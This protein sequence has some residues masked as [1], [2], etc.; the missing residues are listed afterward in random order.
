MKNIEESRK[1]FVEI[2][3]GGVGNSEFRETKRIRFLTLCQ[4]T[5]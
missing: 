4:V 3:A 1:N 5:L 2:S